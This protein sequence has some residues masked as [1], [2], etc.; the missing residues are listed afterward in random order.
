MGVLDWVDG[1]LNTSASV[2]ED[3]ITT[4]SKR[5]ADVGS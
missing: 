1:Q 4:G 5:V 2:N 3:Q